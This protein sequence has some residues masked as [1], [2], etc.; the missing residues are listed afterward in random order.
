[1]DNLIN[2]NIPVHKQNPAENPDT[3]PAQN[4]Y[5]P[6]QSFDK[7]I[8]GIDEKKLSNDARKLWEK[9]FKDLDGDKNV[10]E[11]DFTQEELSMSNGSRTFKDF[12]GGIMGKPWEIAENI[13]TNIK[14]MFIKSMPDNTP[15][16]QG[17]DELSTY[18]KEHKIKEG[19]TFE[20]KGNI[21]SVG[22]GGTISADISDNK[23]IR[24]GF[25]GGKY[26]ETI[27]VEDHND[28]VLYNHEGKK[29]LSREDYDDGSASVR[30]VN[31]NSEY[32]MDDTYIRIRSPK[33]NDDIPQ[34]YIRENK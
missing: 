11:G 23:K 15:K 5:D 3:V 14:A 1:M 13:I 22:K 8:F 18:V 7:S 34:I 6:Q 24:Q 28:S 25:S 31:Y 26:T 27:S 33:K 32:L 12:L 21:Y 17:A 30:I 2:N 20:Y 29:I 9:S 16:P 10:S 4:A 19:D